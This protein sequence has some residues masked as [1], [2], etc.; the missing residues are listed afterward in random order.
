MKARDR[1]L[2]SVISAAKTETTQMP[3]SRGA[4]REAHLIQ[5]RAPQSRQA[6]TQELKRA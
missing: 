3:W 6:T 4:V 1:F 2:K 5:R